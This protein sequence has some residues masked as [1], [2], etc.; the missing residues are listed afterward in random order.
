MMPPDR[1]GPFDTLVLV[2]MAKT[3]RRA[4][5]RARELAENDRRGRLVLVE[6]PDGSS[7]GVI[8]GRAHPSRALEETGR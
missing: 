2:D 7:D 6:R 5:A 8:Y 3:R 1:S 4:W